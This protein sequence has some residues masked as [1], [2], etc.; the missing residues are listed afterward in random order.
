MGNH[1]ALK[2]YLLTVILPFQRFFI[3]QIG[4]D[5]VRSPEHN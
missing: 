1:T 3:Q 4:S 2:F 5:V